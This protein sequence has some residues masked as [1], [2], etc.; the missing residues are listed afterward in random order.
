MATGKVASLDSFSQ[1]IYNQLVPVVPF[2][3]FDS[4]IILK[5]LL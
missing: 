4:S 1:G 2:S 5:N 3:F